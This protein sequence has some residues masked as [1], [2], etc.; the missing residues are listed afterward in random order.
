MRKSGNA[1]LAGIT[2]RQLLEDA[3]LLAGDKMTH[4]ALVLLGTRPALGRRL[5]QAELVFEYRS[6]EA[7]IPFQQRIEFRS[8]FLGTWTNCGPPS[9]FATRCSTTG[10]GSSWGTFPLSTRRWCAKPFSMPSLT[11]I[12]AYQGPFLFASS[13]GGWRSSALVVSRPVS[14]PRTC[15]GGSRPGIA[16]SP[17]PAP[18]AD[19]L[20]DPARAPTGC[21]KSPLR[22]ES[23]GRTSQGRTI[24]RSS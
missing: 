11:G 18:S 15:S 1:A 19:L 3:E 24:T 14:T 7:S 12:T 8:G 6:S 20:S 16:G 2:P 13:R 23:R 17:T 9:I 4:A 5:A 10:K 21:S 22:K